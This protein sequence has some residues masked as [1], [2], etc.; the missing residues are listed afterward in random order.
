LALGAEHRPR[1]VAGW[2]LD[3]RWRRVRLSG[4]T[5]AGGEVVHPSG[6]GAC[7]NHRAVVLYRC[8]VP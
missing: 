1:P 2:V 3:G 7:Q 8:C 5:A 4:R 6:G